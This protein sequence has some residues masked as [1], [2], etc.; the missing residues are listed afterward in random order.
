MRI[1]SLTFAGTIEKGQIAPCAFATASRKIGSEFIEVEINTPSGDF[2]HIVDA[3]C[4]EDVW[5]MA[6]CLQH[7]L[8]GTTGSNAGIN[9][10]HR[11]MKFIAHRTRDRTD[12]MEVTI[13]AANR[14][15]QE[16]TKKE[17]CVEPNE[18]NADLWTVRGRGRVQAHEPMDAAGLRALLRTE[19]TV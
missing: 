19:F 12:E 9:Q 10:F 13:A 8:D 5:S 3:D 16:M 18:V 7:H 15:A 17:V 2:Q 6:K 14:M 4:E 1:T 11:A